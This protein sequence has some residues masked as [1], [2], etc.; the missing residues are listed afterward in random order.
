MLR[1]IGRIMALLLAAALVAGVSYAVVGAA[2]PAG[3]PGGA[4]SGLIAGPG[5]PAAGAAQPGGA[6]KS[7]PAA[8]RFRRRPRRPRRRRPGP[9]RVGQKHRDPRGGHGGGLRRPAAAH[10]A[11]AQRLDDIASVHGA[12]LHDDCVAAQH[13][14]K[15]REGRWQP[16]GL[17]AQA[18]A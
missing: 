12:A 13:P 11:L 6:V 10:A 16:F 9:G 2:G 14:P 5:S 8:W 17:Q 15:G 4:P 1:M 3:R 7:A 18:I